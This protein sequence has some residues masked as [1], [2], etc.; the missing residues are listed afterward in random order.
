MLNEVWF[1]VKFI[2]NFNC[3]WFLH[4]LVFIRTDAYAIFFIILI[5]FNL[6]NRLLWLFFYRNSSC[7][8]F[9]LTWLFFHFVR[10]LN[11][12]VW[13]ISSVFRWGSLNS[14]SWWFN[15]STADWI[16][17]LFF[18][19][20]YWYRFLNVFRIRRNLLLLSILLLIR[21]F[22]LHLFH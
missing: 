18:D 16:F 9:F 15:Y 5:N 10:I 13:I 14:Y 11:I 4:F 21:H 2:F 12:I 17:N 20:Y 22:L 19:N 8:N 1:L 6:Q 7:F 3:T